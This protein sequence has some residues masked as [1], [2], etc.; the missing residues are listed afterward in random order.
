MTTTDPV[1]EFLKQN[2]LDLTRQN[3]LAIAYMGTPPETTEEIIWPAAILR[4]ERKA[5]VKLLRAM[6]I[7]P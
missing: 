4:A 7:K 6:G 2:G 3:Y 1:V 5:D